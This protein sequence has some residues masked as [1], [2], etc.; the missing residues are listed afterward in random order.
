MHTLETYYNELRHLSADIGFFLDRAT[1]EN[2]AK[3]AK[4]ADGVLVDI[5]ST[6]A[7]LEASDMRNAAA[8]SLALIP[9]LTEIRTLVAEVDQKKID[10]YIAAIESLQSE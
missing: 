4:I 7:F 6:N 1:S 5:T 8:S 2:V 3:I 10:G 9:A